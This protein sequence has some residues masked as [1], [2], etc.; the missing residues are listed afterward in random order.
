VAGVTWYEASAYCGS[1]GKRL[2]SVYEWEKTARNGVVSHRGVLMPWGVMASSGLGA[3]R[4]NFSSD[5][6]AVVDA[7]PFGIGPF[8]AYG[9]AGNVGEWTAN[10]FGDGH[11]VTGGSWEGPSYL[12]PNYGSQP[13]TFASSALGFRCARSDGPSD[14]GAGKID[15]DTRTPVYAPVDE[16]TF[17]SLLSHYQYD[18]RPANARV[19]DI[20]DAPAWTRERIWIDGPQADS[21]LLY[22]YAPKGA[23]PPYQT[24]V[25]VPGGSVFCCQTVPD[26]TE[27]AIGPTIQAG[28]AVLV[29]VMKG[30][31]ERGFEPGFQN[32][33]TISVLFRD[34]MV[35]QATELRLGID[36]IETRPDVDADKLAYVGLSF[37][38]GSRLA[39]SV[40]DARYKSVVYI[41]GGIDERVKPT[42]PEADN[43]N[44]A[45]YVRVPTILINGRSD[46]E[47]P[48]LT[49]GLPL[50][51]LL[52]E[53]KEL[54]LIDG[55]G[56][57]VP[58]EDRIPAINGF[59]DRT[60]GPVG[61]R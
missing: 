46:E 61:G 52:T 28:R 38:G 45:P 47:H 54:V 40:V 22:F 25:Y 1:M 41:G 37:G 55:G 21:I 44:F 16:G 8:G 43:V 27:W 35:Q 5:G 60:L 3:R 57:V 49:R 23:A 20:L 59:L 4:A 9:L 33:E 24:L 30:M 11:A 18:R 36:Y 42:L 17:R 14:Q 2:P 39:F 26:E 10:P 56:H 7:Y 13:G 31:L 48:W 51:N 53:P 29:V 6:T 34:L 19:A 50:W 32:P 12:Y 15:L 58:L